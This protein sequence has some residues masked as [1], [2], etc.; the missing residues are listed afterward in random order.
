MSSNG[1]PPAPHVV[2]V[3]ENAR[4]LFPLE[5]APPPPLEGCLQHG[6]GDPA[7]HVSKGS[8]SDPSPHILTSRCI[9]PSAL[10]I[11]MTSSP[12]TTFSPG[13]LFGCSPHVWS[14]QLEIQSI[15]SLISLTR[16]TA[17]L[18]KESFK[19][20]IHNNELSSVVTER[21][22][23]WMAS[24]ASLRL[25]EAKRR[26]HQAAL[27]LERDTEKCACLCQAHLHDHLVATLTAS[28]R[29][30][31]LMRRATRE[32]PAPKGIDPGLN[33]VWATFEAGAACINAVMAEINEMD[34]SP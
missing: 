15:D 27:D 21:H 17:K 22:K 9:V 26:H 14:H 2:A 24:L 20:A 34:L 23:N 12:Q 32:L 10:T 3:D 18:D 19:S 25:Y 5:R 7:L 11:A 29:L 31:R 6:N 1:P 30:H 8:P 33:C 16:I 28:F 13:S 4:W